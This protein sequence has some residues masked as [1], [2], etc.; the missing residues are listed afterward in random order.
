VEAGDT[1]TRLFA[2]WNDDQLR[3]L[4]DADDNRWNYDYDRR[5]R[6]TSLEEPLV[7]GGF[8]SHTTNYTYSV[9][10]QITRIRDQQSRETDYS[11]DQG[12]A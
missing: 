4:Y 10:S 7:G 3:T 2:Y 1:P 9:D 8:L 6:L 12:G 11:Y 5:G